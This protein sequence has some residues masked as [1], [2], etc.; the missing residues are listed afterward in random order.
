MN[1]NQLRYKYYTKYCHELDSIKKEMY[2]IM[3]KKV[4]EKI[5]QL[6]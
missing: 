2:L 6:S 3:F 1:L 5:A 4:S